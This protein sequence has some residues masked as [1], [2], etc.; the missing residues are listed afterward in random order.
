MEEAGPAAQRRRTAAGADLAVVERSAQRVTRHALE[1]HLAHGVWHEVLPCAVRGG[2]GLPALRAFRGFR[3]L[4]GLPGR[5][6]ALGSPGARGA[7]PAAVSK[8][9]PLARDGIT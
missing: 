8:V 1:G 6:A 4:R 7:G 5:P 2:A 3:G 9:A